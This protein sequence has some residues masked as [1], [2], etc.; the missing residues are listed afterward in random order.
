MTGGDAM[1]H[2]DLAAWRAQMG[3]SQRAAAEAL[4]V[5]LN[6]YQQWERGSRFH[7]G[8]PV[9]IDRRTALAC[10]AI[11]AGVGEWVSG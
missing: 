5:R 6:T 2:D 8:A 10:A 11:A 7:D 9:V 4:G 1:T 3:Y